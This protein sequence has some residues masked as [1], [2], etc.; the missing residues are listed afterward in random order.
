VLRLS[1]A[2]GAIPLPRA[3]LPAGMRALPLRRQR[4]RVVE[5][6]LGR[7]ARFCAAAGLVLALV[8]CGPDCASS[9]TG[10]HAGPNGR[11]EGGGSE[12]RRDASITREGAAAAGAAAAAAAEVGGFSVLFW[13]ALALVRKRRVTS[14]TRPFHI[15]APGAPTRDGTEAAE[16]G[17]A[18][19]RE[20]ASGSG[21]GGAGGAEGWAW[22]GARREKLP[23]FTQCPWLT[24]EEPK[25]GE[26]FDI[27]SSVLRYSSGY[28]Q[29]SSTKLN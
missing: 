23:R 28:T 7:T 20:R 5:R 1:G 12:G 18:V 21:S 10:V 22:A 4:A 24:V 6:A 19:A 9:A 17:G 11:Q 27:N 29:L 14:R 8:S 26:V 16:G 3:G 13:Q 15:R 2:R 25:N